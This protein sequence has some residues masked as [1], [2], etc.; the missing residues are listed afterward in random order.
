MDLTYL[1]HACFLIEGE[2]GKKIII[3]P[4]IKNNPLTPVKADDI[5]VDLIVVTHGHFDHLGDA[6]ELARN[7]N[8][9]LVAMVELAN[10]CGKQGV[11]VHGMQVGGSFDFDFAKVKFTLAFHSSSIGSDPVQYMGN[12]VGVIISMDQR[13]IYHAGD[14]GLFGDMELIGRRN[15]LDVALLPIGDNFTMGPGDALEAAKMLKPRAVVPMHYNTWEIINQDVQQ[16]VRQV[17]LET[18]ITPAVLAPGETYMVP[19][20]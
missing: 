10:Y 15:S 13:T 1:G 11:K 20:R 17:E 3:D 14:T 9:P 4:F 12:P 16:F 6:V 2:S 7:N 8:C 18:N 5:K 19:K